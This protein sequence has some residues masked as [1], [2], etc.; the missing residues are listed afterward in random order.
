MASSSDIDQVINELAAA[1]LS[2]VHAR[3][4]RRAGISRGH[5]AHRV[6]RR[7]MAP[8]LAQTYAVGPACHAP[9]FEMQCM[10]GCLAGGDGSTIDGAAAA[11]LSGMWNR[12][13]DV[14]DVSLPGRMIRSAPGTHRFQRTTSGLW[15]PDQGLTSGPI[16]LSNATRIVARFA[17]DATV[18]Q[19]AF[20]IYRATY[21]RFVTLDELETAAAELAGRRGNATFRAAIQLVRDRSAGTR[22]YTEDC[23]VHDFASVGLRMPLVNVRGA[24]GMSRDEPDFVWVKERANVESDGSQHDDLA[25]AADDAIRDAEAAER[26]WRVL[27]VRSHDFHRQRRRAMRLVAR[28]VRGEDVPMYPGTRVLRM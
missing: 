4:L 19:T 2:V 22:C 18:Q 24:L 23:Y 26:G 20:V 5:V 16:P 13:V 10:A 27:R 12:R 8:L 17:C 21:L 25:Q 6:E 9:T 1:T 11:S 15:L 7:S 3:D 14:I 28:F